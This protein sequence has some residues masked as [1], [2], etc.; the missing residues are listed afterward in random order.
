MEFANPRGRAGTTTVVV[1]SEASGGADVAV[2]DA[3]VV[4]GGA[5]DLPSE[6]KNLQ[7]SPLLHFPSTKN[8]QTVELGSR[9]GDLAPVF[10]FP[11]DGFFFL[12]LAFFFP[13]VMLLAVAVV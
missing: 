7:S 9:G 1:A 13:M 11:C 2:V 3:V 10:L 5:A 12:L 6:C 8:L 4:A